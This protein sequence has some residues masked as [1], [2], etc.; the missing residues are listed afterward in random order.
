MAYTVVMDVTSITVT[1]LKVENCSNTVTIPGN[2]V[3]IDI[4]CLASSDRQEYN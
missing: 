4:D 2:S 1:V 3:N